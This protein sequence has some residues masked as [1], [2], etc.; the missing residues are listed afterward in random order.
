MEYTWINLGVQ[1]FEPETGV[2]KRTNEI[3]TKLIE[4]T[5][6]L[7]I[8]VDKTK[9]EHD[10]QEAH[11]ADEYQ[12]WFLKDT[13]EIT[14]MQLLHGYDEKEADLLNEMKVIGNYDQ[15]SLPSM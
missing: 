2:L 11:C 7:G 12:L 14:V 5:W 9:E 6:E 3:Q 10:K 15:V 4:L 13:L 1:H 8:A